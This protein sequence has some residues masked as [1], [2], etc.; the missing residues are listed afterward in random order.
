[1]PRLTA[2]DEL[3][4]HQI[5]EPFP[6]VQTHHEH[7]RDSYFFVVHPRTGP[8]DVLL[9]TMA[10]FPKRE[11]MDSLQMGQIGGQH[12]FGRYERPYGD[13]PHTPV[14]GPVTIE[15]VEPYKTLRLKADGAAGATVG[16]DLTFTARTAAYGL[17]RGTMKA[18]HEIIWDQS[19]FFQAGDFNGTYT[20]QG[21]T[22]TVDNWWGQRDHSWGIRDHARCPMWMWFAVQLEDGMLGV[23]H[24]EYPNGARVFTDGCWAPADGGAP[25]PLIDFRHD[26][27]WIDRDGNPADYGRDGAGTTGLAGRVEFTLEGGRTI[28]VEGEGTRCAPYG[29]YGGGQHQMSVRTDDGRKGMAIYE[30]T[31]TYHH[32]FFPIARAERLPPG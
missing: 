24:W 27:H 9:L 26:L 25:V 10:Q 30:L 22:H 13:D 17:R 28:A 3:F 5:P 8:G 1:M 15:I 2:A 12:V 21:V 11:V 32:R 16:V 7:W 31:G 14:V 23:W 6:N 19:H 4:V 18:G 20:Y 29:Q